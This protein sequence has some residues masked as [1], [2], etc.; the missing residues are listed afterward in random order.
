MT[1]VRR[2]LPRTRGG[3]AWPPAGVVVA[4]AEVTP[5]VVER[6]PAEP[7]RDET[8]HVADHVSSPSPAVSSLNAPGE[9]ATADRAA[10]AGSASAPA[11]SALRR[12][13]PRIAGGE[14]WPPAGAVPVLLA[15]PAAQ[16][17]EGAAAVAP[18]T[19]SASAIDASAAASAA[20]PAM[21]AASSA[22]APAPAP[23]GA[24]AASGSA[25]RRGLP[26]VGGGEP[27]PPAGTAVVARS[28]V[29]PAP[30]EA[31]ESVAV[32]TDAVSPVV[33]AEAAARRRP[34]AR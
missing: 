20:T 27:W 21:A 30:S 9:A 34:G 3:E 15:S 32:A 17:V 25:L 26:R 16:A 2:G 22:P 11:G 14:P 28:A 6:A 23:A 12:G 8:R 5:V 4:G 13:L 7:A 24:P 19:A 31:T 18:S 10:H 1:T 29:E 33:V